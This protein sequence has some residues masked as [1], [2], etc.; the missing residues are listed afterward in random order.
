M[1]SVMACD[2]ARLGFVRQTKSV[3]V[4]ESGER[5][6][7]YLCEG[8]C[9]RRL[10]RIYRDA[11]DCSGVVCSALVDARKGKRPIFTDSLSCAV[12]Q[13][14]MSCSLTSCHSED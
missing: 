1:W 5:K 8:V 9:V 14:H 11:S 13:W 7:E 10:T 2:V 3:C 4:H 6:R 12:S